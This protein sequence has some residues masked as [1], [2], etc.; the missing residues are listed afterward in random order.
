M[1]LTISPLHRLVMLSSRSWLLGHALLCLQALLSTTRKNAAPPNA[2]GFLDRS[3][4]QAGYTCYREALYSR[5][6]GNHSA[7]LEGE[8]IG[9]GYFGFA[10]HFAF[11]SGLLFPAFLQEA[12]ENPALFYLVELSSS[13][14]IAL[15]LTYCMIVG[16]M[17]SVALRAYRT[18]NLS[19]HVEVRWDELLS[20]GIV[21]KGRLIGQLLGLPFGTFPG[22][23]KTGLSYRLDGEAPIAVS[24]AGPGRWDRPVALG[25]LALAAPL[26]MLAV[27]ASNGS[28]PPL[29][30]GFELLV[31]ITVPLCCISLLGTFL[32]GRGA[33]KTAV[34][35]QWKAQTGTRHERVHG[36]DLSEVKRHLEQRGQA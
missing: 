2:T 18:N 28:I 16:H 35:E 34:V 13:A 9:S 29:P 12:L 31:R 1:P 10:F 26:V 21:G 33:Y 32:T 20:K 22:V 23:L 7:T 24:A 30:K 36:F 4:R 8:F 3:A 14:G 27:L 5:V 15:F 25:A 17:G 6:A 19:E 11:V